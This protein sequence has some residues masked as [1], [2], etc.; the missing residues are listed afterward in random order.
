V[1]D[2]GLVRSVALALVA[3][4]LVG[5]CVVNVSPDQTFES[6]AATAASARPSA[7]PPSAPSASASGLRYVAL[8]DSYT[9]G[10][11]VEPAERFPDQLVAAL[12]PHGPPLDL[13]ANLATNGYTSRDVIDIELP[14]LDTY[15]PEFVTLLIGVNDVVQGV[16][17]EDYERN[18]VTVLDALLERLA[19][20]RV[21]VV[22][23][24]E[25]TVT[26]QGANYG[27]PRVQRAGIQGNNAAM[28]RLA[29]QRGIAYVDIYDLSLRAETDRSLVADDGLHP[30]GAQ[31]ALWVE[32][33]LPVVEAAIGR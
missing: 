25:Y 32:R 33:L 27:D 23:I 10:T 26:P 4:V 1:R 13:V 6:S 9:I 24:P 7:S 11:S 18:V 2:W 20:E 28:E 14:A 31:Y 19:P 17:L 12:G 16:P 8:G 29:A 30:S 3:L 15:D 21:V 5:G 22:A